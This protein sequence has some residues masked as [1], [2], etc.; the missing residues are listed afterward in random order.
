MR[1]PNFEIG[2]ILSGK[3]VAL[4]RFYSEITQEDIKGNYK[5]QPKY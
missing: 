3:I 5:K 2:W 4:R 1:I